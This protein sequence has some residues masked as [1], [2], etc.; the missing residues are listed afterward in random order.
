MSPPASIDFEGFFFKRCLI[1]RVRNQFSKRLSCADRALHVTR[2]AVA[3]EQSETWKSNRWG[4]IRRRGSA[5]FS[6]FTE[7]DQEADDAY[8]RQEEAVYA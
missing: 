4:S 3:R 8:D 7:E 2:R 5:S 1:G 6:E